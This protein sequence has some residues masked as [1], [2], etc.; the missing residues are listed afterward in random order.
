[1]KKILNKLTM[2]IATLSLAAAVLVPVTTPAFASSDCAPNEG[3]SGAVN[4]G[5]SQG[6]GQATNLF[7]DGSV[8][9]TIINTM[10]FITGL[11]SVIMIIY[12]GIRYV[13][14]HGDTSQVKSAQNTLIYAIVGLVVSIVAYAVVSWVSGLWGADGGAGAGK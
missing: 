1:M 14:A 10:L 9:T 5:C 7:G 8:V 12:A 3:L 4:T 6:K 13:T 11:L 2:G